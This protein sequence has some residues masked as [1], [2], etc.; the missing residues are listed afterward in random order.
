MN[1]VYEE[2]II[3]HFSSRTTF[4]VVKSHWNSL[5]EIEALAVKDINI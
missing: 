5:I 1:K 2:K 3:G 4:S